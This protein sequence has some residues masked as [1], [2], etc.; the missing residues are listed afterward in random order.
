MNK[1]TILIVDDEADIR[2][3]L[4]FNLSAAGY[5]T[6]EAGT[7][8]AALIQI[9]NGAAVDLIL[10]DVMLPGMSGF[11]L[12]DTLRKVD[13]CT[14][15]IVFLTA[16]GAENDLLTGFSAGGDDYISKPFSVNEVL[17][18]IKAVLKRSAA[19]APTSPATVIIDG[20]SIDSNNHTVAV[21]GVVVPFSRKEFDILYLLATNRGKTF[22]RADF[23][24]IL[25]QDAPYVLER[26][27]D[28][29][30]ARIR[31]KIGPYR[32]L[33]VNR[34]GFGYSIDTE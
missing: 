1:M 5:Q 23:I 8:E 26:T 9:R 6:L 25:W 33:I 13:N 20:L 3:I 18:R 12:A 7:A 10:L 19:S 17:A 4:A 16:R 29:H 28:V 30:I 2:E 14:I 22:S 24:K 31:G 15:P 11:K 27:V 21:D 34:P 32:N